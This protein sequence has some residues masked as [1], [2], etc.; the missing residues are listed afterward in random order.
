MDISDANKKIVNS[1]LNVRILNLGSSTAS[2]ARVISQSIPPGTVVE[3]NTILELEI[4]YTDF[5]D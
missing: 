5:E 4:L 1:G 3:K 2:G